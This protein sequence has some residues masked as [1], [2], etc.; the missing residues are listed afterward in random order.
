MRQF[1]LWA[2]ACARFQVD[3]SGGDCFTLRAPEDRPSLFNGAS[4]VRFTFGEHAG[5]TTEH[6]TL[7]SRMFQWVL[8]QLGET[9]NQRHSVPN[10][11][12]QSI[13]EIGPKLFEAYKV[14][15]GSVQLAGC[16][17]EDRPLLRVT[18]RSTDASSGESRLRHR[19]FTPD[20]GRVSNELA[21]TLG[22][23]ELVPAIQFRRSLADADVQQWISVARTANAP[24]VESAESS[25]AADE[26]LAATVVW[27]KYADGKL[28]FTIGE[29]NV[30]LP[31]AGWAR[32][33]AR[34]LQ[35]PPP[36]VCP[37]S[38][39]RSHHLQATDDG[40]ITV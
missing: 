33:L 19:F 8:K 15:S 10:D 29:Q 14:D 32:L 25:G 9:D 30:E 1:V 37:L 7:D 21:E 40:R 36:Y 22:A 39:L 24:G 23:D 5:P 3:E 34:G 26:F 20:G 12:P 31:F 28:R 2:L 17:L 16:A 13:H 35:E 4:S 18:V 27:L 11:Y 38:G 6:V